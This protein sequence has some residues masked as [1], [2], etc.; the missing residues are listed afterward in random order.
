MRTLPNTIHKI[1]S[2]WI[3]DLNVRPEMIELLEENTGRT[4]SDINRSKILY[5]SP[6][7]VTEVKTNVNKWDLIKLKNFCTAKATISSVQFSHSLVSDCL[8]SHELQHARPPRPSPT[9]Q[10]YTNS[11]PLSTWCHL[12]N[13]SSAIPFSSC[14]QY[15]PTSGSFQMSQLLTS[16]SYRKL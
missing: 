12:T 16:F 14:L 2:K 13:S 7:R 5:D 10:V 8:L 6:P 4:L 15:F 11:C 3:K 9:P 1:N